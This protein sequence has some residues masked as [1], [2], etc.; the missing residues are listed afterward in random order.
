[1][2][3]KSDPPEINT[4][5]GEGAVFKGE[6]SFSGAVRIDGTFDG[7]VQ[8]PEAS[9]IIGPKGAVSGELDLQELVVLGRYEGTARVSGLTHLVSGSSSSVEITTGH[10]MVEQGAILNG[11]V[12]MGGSEKTPKRHRGK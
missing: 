9:L 10:L 1:M 4:L 5:L 3:K 6:L 8:S 12:Q 2:K 11:T 7:R